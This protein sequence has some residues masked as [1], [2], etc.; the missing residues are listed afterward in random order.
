MRTSIEKKVDRVHA[1]RSIPVASHIE[2]NIRLATTD[3]ARAIAEIHVRAWQAAYQGL[4]P[5]EHLLSM[6]V[7]R[8]EG[9]WLETL[10]TGPGETR[11]A[12]DEGRILGWISTG[13]SRDEDA[14]PQTGE[15]YAMYLHP[16]HWRQGIGQALWEAGKASLVAAGF[17]AATLWVLT[18]N[19]RARRFYEA[20][21]FAPDPGH[22]KTFG[23]C[24]EVI[25]EFRMRCSL[26]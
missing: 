4:I 18:G 7:D 22:E 11:V 25:P 10:A 6:S 13:P 12:E 5:E 19:E 26:R 15:L 2:V 14:T 17:Q 21:G 9:K 24:G 1:A 8:R 3:D 16:D 23:L 20:N